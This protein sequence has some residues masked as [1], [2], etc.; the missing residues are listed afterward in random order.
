VRDEVQLLSQ[1]EGLEGQ[2][3]M[4]LKPIRHGSPRSYSEKPRKTRESFLETRRSMTREE[5]IDRLKKD[6]G[7]LTHSLAHTYTTH[8]LTHQ[9]LLLQGDFFLTSRFDDG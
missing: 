9:H 7:R 5:S 2:V 8:S 3:L 6:E 4:A 1:P